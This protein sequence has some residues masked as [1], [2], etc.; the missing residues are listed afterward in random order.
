MKKNIIALLGSLAMVQI[1]CKSKLGDC[2]LNE[3]KTIFTVPS[4]YEGAVTGYTHYILIKDFSKNCLDSLTLVEYALAYMDSIKSSKPATVIKFFN[5]TEKFVPGE[6][7]Q[8]MKEINKDCLV[9]IGFDVQSWKP[10]D[11]IF[12]DNNGRIVYWGGKWVPFPKGSDIYKM[13]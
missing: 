3:V 9:T 7:S 11:F 1:S 2:K 12:Y 8:I 5:S 6:T 4:I 13:K 10:N